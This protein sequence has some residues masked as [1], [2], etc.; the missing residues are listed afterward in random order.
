MHHD[1]HAG[2]DVEVAVLEGACEGED[3]WNVV[4]RGGVAG[5]GYGGGAGGGEERV[6]GNAAGKWG[7][8][9]HW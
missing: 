5:G 4:V 9:V 3:E 6:G 1:V 7:V 8:V 2:V